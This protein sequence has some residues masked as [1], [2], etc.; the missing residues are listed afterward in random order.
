MSKPVNVLDLCTGTGC[1]PLLFQHELS[2]QSLGEDTIA[3]IVGV[4]ISSTALSLAEENKAIQLRELRTSASPNAK[5]LDLL[6]NIHFLQADVLAR[7]GPSS[8]TSRLQQIQTNRS[9]PSYEIII[10]NPPYI[11]SSAFRRT[12][13]ASVRKF[14]P[15]LALVPPSTDSGLF[16][17]GSANNHSVDDGD[18][19][20]PCVLEIAAECD[21]KV[22]LVEVADMEQACRVAAMADGW[23]VEIWRDDPAARGESGKEFVGVGGEGGRQVRVCGTGNGRSVLFTKGDWIRG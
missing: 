6:R 13:A 2:K 8:V 16:P 21:A 20:Y 17:S 19:F 11:S 9:N 1:I 5:T 14:E 15:K 3:N 7:S 4:D 23:H 22:V 12:T 10:S 18:I